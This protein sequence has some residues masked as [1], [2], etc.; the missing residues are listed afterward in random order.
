MNQ[1]QQPRPWWKDNWAVLALL[2]AV[3]VIAATGILGYWRSWQRPFWDWL[4]LLIIP[5]VLA[6]AA[7]WFNTQTRKSEQERAQREKELEQER[8]QREKERDLERAQREKE[9]EQERAQR[10]KENDRERAEDRAQEEALQHYLDRMSELVLDKN[11]RESELDDAVRAAA[12]ARTLTVLRSLDGNRKGQVAMFLHEADL[13]GR[14]II[15]EVGERHGIEAIIDLGGAD[16][17]GAILIGAMLLGAYL[18]DADLPSADLSDAVLTGAD[19]RGANLSNA[20]L[21]GADLIGANLSPTNLR[22]ADLTYTNL[23]LADLTYTNLYPTNLRHADLSGADLSL[24]K[25]H[26]A[27]LYDA[28]LRGAKLHDVNLSNAK[29][30]TN[31]QLAQAESLVGATMPDGTVMTEEDWEEFKKQYRSE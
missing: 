23:R 29:G 2:A 18:R 19:L 9:L 4:D 16:L 5:L 24:A 12:R 1:D 6:L 25:L 30:W 14:V 10:E 15:D 17:S 26:G 3:I 28:N 31:E 21:R 20:D 11:L 27:D 8:A 13:I 7:L 22:G